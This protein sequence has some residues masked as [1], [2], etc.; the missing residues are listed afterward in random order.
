MIRK[1]NGTM[2]HFNTLWAVVEVI[3]AP[4]G[5]TALR[6][7]RDKLNAAGFTAYAGTGDLFPDSCALVYP[8]DDDGYYKEDEM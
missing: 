1:G 8:V 2:P 4:D 5:E 6:T 3:D 7:L